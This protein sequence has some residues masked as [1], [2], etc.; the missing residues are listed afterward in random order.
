MKEARG[1]PHRSH[2]ESSM[3][4]E[5]RMSEPCSCRCRYCTCPRSTRRCDKICH[6]CAD[7]RHQGDTAMEGVT[8]VRLIDVLS[9]I[10]GGE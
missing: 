2:L 3:G 9:A 8:V 1:W 10:E 5:H 7:G 6:W 4:R